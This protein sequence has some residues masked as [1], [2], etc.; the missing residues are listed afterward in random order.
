MKK[1]AEIV[2]KCLKNKKITQ[3]ALAERLKEDP[4]LISQQLR[5]D[6]DMKMERFFDV[7]EHIGYGVEIVERKDEQNV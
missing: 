3:R 4:R 2:K 1:A 7:L 5:R 6:K